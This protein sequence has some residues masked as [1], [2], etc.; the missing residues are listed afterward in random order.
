MS[1]QATGPAAVAPSAP[2]L[3]APIDS[4]AML[5]DL[6]AELARAIHDV[7][8]P[9]AII[10]GNAQLLVE[11]A[12]ALELGDEIAIPIRDIDEASRVLD[13]RLRQLSLLREEIAN[14]LGQGDSITGLHGLAD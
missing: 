5:S 2:G 4:V 12:H 9:L 11:L 13:E 10:S 3:H 8:N 6:R 7:N 1:I 14:A